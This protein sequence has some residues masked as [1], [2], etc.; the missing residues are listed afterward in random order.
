MAGAG[1]AVRQRVLR[2]AEALDY[3]PNR[4]ARGLRARHRKVVGVLLPDLQNPFFTGIVRGVE[5]VLCQAGFTLLLGHSDGLAERERSHLRVLRGEGADGLIFIPGNGPG[6]SY[7]ALRNWK[8]PVVSVD[9]SPRGLAVDLVTATNRDGAREATRHLLALGHGSVALINGPAEFDVAQERE[10]GYRDALREA[11]CAFRADLVAHGDFRQAS[12]QAGMAR[13]L[14]LE[15]PARAV[16]VANNLMTLGALQ[17]IHERALSIPEDVAI[18]G[19]DDMPWATSLRPPLTAVAQPAEEMGRKAARLLLER[20]EDPG[21]PA[22]RVVLP[23][24]LVIRA[25][26]G[27]ARDHS[28][29]VLSAA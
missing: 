28:A 4:L 5:E 13:L 10:A 16:L 14:D 23:T 2:A 7:E 8:V 20:L 6:A 17:A 11:G 19:F 26:C 9:R 29:S 21:Q 22:R 18:V 24:R 12:A 3:H 25:S 27:A 15:A 1:A